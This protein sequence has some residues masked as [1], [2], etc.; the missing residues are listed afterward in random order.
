[1]S[2][3]TSPQF[4]ASLR[5]LFGGRLS[6]AQVDGL[7]QILAATEALPPEHRAY[8]L[9]TAR[10][11]TGGAMQP[12]REIGR[13]KGRPYGLVDA[14]GK[15]PYGRGLVQ[16]TWAA[17]Y[18]RAD[19]ELGLGGRLAADYDLALDPGISVQVLVRG[20]VEGWFTGR[21]LSDFLPGDYLAARRVVNGSDRAEKIAAEA[22]RFEAALA[23]AAAEGGL[24]PA[25]L[26]RIFRALLPVLQRI[27]GHRMGGAG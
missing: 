20:M 7:R 15:A 3:I 22:R 13:G 4:Y 26:A 6:Q 17:N 11:E 8:I 23:L 21:K 12:L 9:A 25:P 5:P 19:R 10:H 24:G 1:M 2:V 18:A 27:L 16:L 14:T